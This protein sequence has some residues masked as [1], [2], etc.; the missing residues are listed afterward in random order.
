MTESCYFASVEG[1]KPAEFY[2]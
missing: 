1:P 2:S